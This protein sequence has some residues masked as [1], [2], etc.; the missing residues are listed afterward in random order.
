VVGTD[1][2]DDRSLTAAVVVRFGHEESTLYGEGVSKPL[3]GV[4]R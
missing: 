1:V 4:S 2:E 3:C